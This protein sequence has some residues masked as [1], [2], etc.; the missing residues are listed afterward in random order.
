MNFLKTLKESGAINQSLFPIIFGELLEDEDYWYEI[1]NDIPRL[2]RD[3]LLL[4][5]G[6]TQAYCFAL[7]HNKNTTIYDIHIPDSSLNAVQN[8]H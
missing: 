2:S 4:Y 5:L 8:S 3:I 1:E 6:L 7:A